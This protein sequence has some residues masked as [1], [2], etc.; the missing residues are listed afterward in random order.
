M[1]E[2]KN[3]FIQSKMNQDLDARI[4]P[5]GQYRSGLNVSIS[6]SESADVGALETVLGNLEI[7]DFLYFIRPN[8]I[9][10]VIQDLSENQ[11]KSICLT[12]DYSLPSDFSFAMYL[13]TSA[14]FS[15]VITAS[16]PLSQSPT[17]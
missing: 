7:T 9:L 14:G 5:N 8:E 11:K 4:I 12:V 2:S 1:A 16:S 3:T 13:S 6:R 15:N 10:N 17:S